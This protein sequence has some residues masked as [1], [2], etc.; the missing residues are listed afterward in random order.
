MSLLDSLFSDSKKKYIQPLFKVK[1]NDTD[2]V[3]KWVLEAFQLTIERNKDK[4]QEMKENISLY[5]GDAIKPIVV[6][7]NRT[8]D[9]SS[10]DQLHDSKLYVNKLYNHTEFWV[11]KMTEQKPNVS[12]GPANTDHEDRV[13]AK[14]AK[15]LLDS[16]FYEN[17]FDKIDREF[18]LNK[19]VAGEHYLAVVWNPN[20]GE[21][22]PDSK[23]AREEG[24]PVQL[25]DNK[26]PA[27]LNEPIYVGDVEYKHLPAWRVLPEPQETYDKCN[28][29]MY[30]ECEQIDVLKKRYPK[31]G[32]KIRP[33]LSL[34]DVGEGFSTDYLEKLQEEHKTI[35]ITVWHKANELL[36]EGREIVMTADGTVLI[37]RPLP[38]TIKNAFPVVRDTGIDVPGEQRGMSWYQNVKGL[39]Y[40]HF[41]LNSMVL[42][43]QKIFS[44]PKWVVQHGSV[45]IKQLGN[46]RT[47]LQV[48]GAKD[49]YILQPNA[50]PAEV[51]D[52]ITKLENDM[53]EAV[54]G[55][56]TTPE[57]IPARI[58]SAVALQFLFEQDQ[59]RF[60]G[61]I[62][63]R[64]R[65]LIEIAKLTLSVAA[66]YYD[67]SDQRLIKII[68]KNQEPDV[69]FFEFANFNRPYDIRI[70]ASSALPETKSAKI[71]TV[72]EIAKT[73]P[74]AF[75]QEQL[76]DLLDLG[77]TEKMYNIKT[78][79]LK[80]AE[81][82]VQDILAGTP[83]PPPEGYEDLMTY[84]EVFSG[85]AQER[86]FKDS[87]PEDKRQL[88][89]DYLGAI[90]MLMWEK[91]QIN[92]AF[93]QLMA[94][95]PLYPLVFTPPPPPPTPEELAAQAELDQQAD[96]EATMAAADLA[97]QVVSE[98]VTNNNI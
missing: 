58:D 95:M 39:Q 9:S 10:L 85:E 38:Y 6:S 52:H 25:S 63:K 55:Q 2:G 45:D 87:V 21:E 79:A 42:A 7:H 46:A 3:K 75:T 19:T 33:D 16:L 54:R 78:R 32:K 50:T 96:A 41:F 13:G 26:E 60:N 51:F 64:N 12:V 98:E 18:E 62:A 69:K 61:S 93:A 53:A 40:Q 65:R 71:A 88:V 67:E 90:E 74:D 1:R 28:W 84:W 37:D 72:I 97:N 86:K 5:K 11:N 22:H 80:A 49:P 68:G 17:D 8:P 36:P 23:K 89:L 94:T 47:V 27:P 59:Q 14:V 15:A 83:V 77:S 81:S 56:F 4:I 57:N 29:L 66:D 44:Y 31:N 24:T 73:M 70:E 43:N 48:R 82:I 34:K 30:W 92:P 76:F 35:V 91:A 20:K